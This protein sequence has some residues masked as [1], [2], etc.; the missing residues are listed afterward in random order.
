MEVAWEEQRYEYGYEY[1]QTIQNI[2]GEAQMVSRQEQY[3]FSPKGSGK[4]SK[5]KGKGKGKTGGKG[6]GGNGG[7]PPKFNINKCETYALSW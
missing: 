2:Q 5:G 4:G 6:K 3:Y 1:G 7:E